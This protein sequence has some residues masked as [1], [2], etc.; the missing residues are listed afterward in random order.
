MFFNYSFSNK[1][2]LPLGADQGNFHSLKVLKFFEVAS[3]EFKWVSWWRVIT[4]KTWNPKALIGWLD[5]DF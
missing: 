5:V 2:P 4:P 1:M 3:F